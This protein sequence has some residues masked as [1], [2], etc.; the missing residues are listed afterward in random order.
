MTT[1]VL[2][3]HVLI[4]AHARHQPWP[5]NIANTGLCCSHFESSSPS[6]LTE[7]LQ[8][9]GDLIQEY[10]S[11]STPSARLSP[12]ASSSSSSSSSFSLSTA[13]AKVT[14][15]TFASP[16]DQIGLSSK[17]GA[18]PHVLSYALYSASL[19]RAYCEHNGYSFRAFNASTVGPS[20]MKEMGTDDLRWV[21]VKLLYDAL[22]P[23]TGWARDQDYLVWMDADAVVLDFG[24]RIMED[25]VERQEVEVQ[26]L[27]Q[28]R[29]SDDDYNY[30]D[31]DGNNF[32]RNNNQRNDRM[33]TDSS[34]SNNN[35]R[36]D[37]LASADIRMGLINTGVLIVR[38]SPSA[39]AFL[40][41]WWTIADRTHTCDQDAFDMVFKEH[42]AIETNRKN[43]RGK[44]RSD[45]GGSGS[46]SRSAPYDNGMSLMSPIEERIRV[47]PMNALN[48]HPPAK[49]RQQPQDPVLHLMGESVNLRKTVFRF[50]LEAVCTARTGAVVRNIVLCNLI[51][52]IYSFIFINTI[53]LFLLLLKRLLLSF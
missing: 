7:C 18:D 1:T 30:N 4:I 40:R 37:L 13:T 43:N 51:I 6:Q 36:I 26:R 33:T 27:Q 52:L 25:I 34:S 9:Q 28:Q 44:R 47:L 41:R 12:A 42:L 20:K 38:N 46:G 10:T 21:K 48:S 35:K 32:E 39:R 5:L 16:G 24:L 8:N 31:N 14:L 17:A 11:T 22:D 53:R 3:V 45:D 15:F 29:I 50:G 2:L 19:V 23:I 49:L